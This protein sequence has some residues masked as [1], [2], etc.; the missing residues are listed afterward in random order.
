MDS[1]DGI[2]VSKDY[3]NGLFESERKSETMSNI[4]WLQ[5]LR[6][7]FGVFALTENKKLKDKINQAYRARDKLCSELVACVTCI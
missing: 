4:C 1:V 3:D 2:S 7:E 5:L 6:L